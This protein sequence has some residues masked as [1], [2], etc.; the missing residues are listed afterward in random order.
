M[1]RKKINVFLP[2]TS[3]SMYLSE[4]VITQQ[5][6]QGECNILLNPHGFN[7]DSLLWDSVWMDDIPRMNSR[8]IFKKV[9]INFHYIRRLSS[10]FKR[11]KPN[12]EVV[13]QELCNFY[14]VDLYHVLTNHIFSKYQFRARFIIEDG[15]LNYYESEGT[16]LK[17][18]RLKNLYYGFFGLSFKALLNK[19]HLTG[20]YL[21]SVCKQF[22]TNPN[23][24]LIPDKSILIN[25]GKVPIETSFSDVLLILGQEPLIMSGMSYKVYSGYIID[26]I[27]IAENTYGTYKEVIY[28]PHP[29][30]EENLLL[31][32]KELLWNGKEDINFYLDKKTVEQSLLE[33]LPK[34]IF[35]FRSTS[36]ISIKNMSNGR[37]NIH[38]YIPEG[39]KVNHRI[40]NVLRVL[41]IEIHRN[42]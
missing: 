30:A 3:Y 7:H 38:A 9:L 10:Y 13:N 20:I 39:L 32:V 19:T 28:K 33:I 5:N 23:E 27:N 41:N 6:L 21:D 18:V 2:I 8:R 14:Y 25:L 31:K 24:T 12:L 1:I 11:I 42:V 15:M 35:S 26:M 36:L 29:R 16:V 17:L 22:V 4:L 37:I 40:E 34:T